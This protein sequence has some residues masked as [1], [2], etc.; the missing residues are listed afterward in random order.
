MIELDDNFAPVIDGKDL[1]EVGGLA[2]FEQHIKVEAT[3]RLYDVMQDYRSA[4][5]PPK[6]QL[7]VTRIAR[8]S[9]IIDNIQSVNVYRSQKD[10][11]SGYEVE[12]KYIGND[13]F[14]FLLEI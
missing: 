10:N 4:D 2:K 1:E 12:V 14:D 7:E 11:R 5:V 13:R 9:S 6:I 3:A 8:E